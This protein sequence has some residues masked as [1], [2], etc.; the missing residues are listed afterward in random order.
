MPDVMDNISCLSLPAERFFEIGGME[1]RDEKA[2]HIKNRKEAVS[3]V[4]A[5]PFSCFALKSNGLCPH[6]RMHTV[7]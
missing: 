7:A 3:K 4:L 5:F 6:H 1:D 2:A